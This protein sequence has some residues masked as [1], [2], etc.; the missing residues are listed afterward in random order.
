MSELAPEWL[1]P[2]TLAEALALKAE[3]GEEAT[4]VAGGT[5]LAI[6][7]N[8]RFLAP[9]RFLSLR[10]VPELTGIEANGEL[11]LV[12][13]PADAHDTERMVAAYLS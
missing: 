7:L 11:R 6:L 5:F 2:Q 13:S 4:V 9:Q 1:A 12:L 8:Q 3:Y 10:V